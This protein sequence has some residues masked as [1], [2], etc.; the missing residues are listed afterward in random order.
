MLLC[1]SNRQLFVFIVC[2]YL[3]NV[4]FL[5]IEEY[6]VRNITRGFSSKVCNGHECLSAIGRF[7]VQKSNTM[8]SVWNQPSIFLSTA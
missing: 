7:L 8:L 4:L 3:S 1:P 2:K 5:L 6:R